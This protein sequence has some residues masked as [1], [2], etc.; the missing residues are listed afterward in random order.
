MD[1]RSARRARIASASEPRRRTLMT[2]ARTTFVV[3]AIAT[4]AGI[5]CY[6]AVVHSPAYDEPAY[7]ASGIAY[8]QTGRCD[9]YRVNPPL[10]RAIAAIP[11]VVQGARVELRPPAN[12]TFS[13]DEVGYGAQVFA[14]R[15]WRAF[16][17][18]I[19]GRLVSGAL[20]V[21]CCLLC[22]RVALQRYG[23]ASALAALLLFGFL[24]DVLAH[25][26]LMTPDLGAA[27]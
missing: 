7:L 23:G 16:N 6:G 27:A 21:G 3:L 15:R 1:S 14:H 10:A 4:H 20:S 19:A 5:Q 18:L 13:R 22:W 24:P 9:L 26:H 2:I 11:A 8:W 17:D 25:G 12:E